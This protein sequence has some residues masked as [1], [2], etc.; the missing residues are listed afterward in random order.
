MT[1][2]DLN[3]LLEEDSSEQGLSFVPIPE[4]FLEPDDP[5][6]TMTPEEAVSE[7]QTIRLYK[8]SLDG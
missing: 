4:G 3:N 7:L 6:F 1:L 8:E 2:E 5:I